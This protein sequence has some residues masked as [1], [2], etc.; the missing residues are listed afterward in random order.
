MKLEKPYQE[1]LKEIISYDKDIEEDFNSFAYKKIIEEKILPNII[2]LLYFTDNKNS[3]GSTILEESLN[4]NQLFK[5]NYLNRQKK[6]H[7]IKEYFEI[8]EKELIKK[9]EI[10]YQNIESIIENNYMFRDIKITKKDI[11][12]YGGSIIN[13]FKEFLKFKEEI[14][15]FKINASEIKELARSIRQDL[16]YKYS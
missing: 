4:I 3:L 15:C 16:K 11:A 2:D 12:E 14:D 6:G 5:I 7:A 1:T 8:F 13:S 10:L 9:K